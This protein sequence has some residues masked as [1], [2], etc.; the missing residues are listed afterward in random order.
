M[1]KFLS[2]DIASLVCKKAK[3]INGMA[4]QLGT[5]T[6]AN[7]APSTLGW[8]KDLPAIPRQTARSATVPA[9]LERW[10]QRSYL[11]RLGEK[12]FTRYRK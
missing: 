6:I 4:L 9:G 1:H 7:L 12:T 11:Y 2:D 8:V 5:V 3:A 10:Q